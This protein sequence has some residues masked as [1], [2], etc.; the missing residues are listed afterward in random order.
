[1]LD[2]LQQHVIVGSLLGDGSISATGGGKRFRFEVRHGAK[3]KE[4]LDWKYE[5]LK[6]LVRTPPKYQEQNNSWRFRTISFPEFTDFR[7]WFYH[8]TQKVIPDELENLITHPKVLAVWYM[9]DGNLRREYGKTYGCMLNS[10]SFT[11][12]D[13]KKLSEL[14]RKE[15]GI[16]PM[17]QRNHGKY[18]LYFGAGSWRKF[19]AIVTP[20]IVPSMRYKLS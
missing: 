17:L 1:M 13:N 5:V 19:C 2:E 11:Y 6:N 14:L 8:G 16:A 15:Y 4:Y 20:Y 10:Q 9:D 18:R 12:D 7:R 3:Q